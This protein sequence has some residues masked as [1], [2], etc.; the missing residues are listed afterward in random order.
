MDMESRELLQE[1]IGWTAFGYS[2]YFYINPFLT[3]H[4]LIKGKIS[5]EETPIGLVTLSYISCFCWYIYSNLL[6]CNPIKIS[7]LVGTI[8][9]GLLIIIYLYYEIKDYL[10]DTILNALI[11]ITGSYL[12]YLVLDTII[13]NDETVG[14]ICIAVVCILCIFQI[15][16][17]FKALAEKNLN[18]ININQSWMTL[19][20]VTLWGIY[21]YMAS[22]LYVVFPQ[23]LFGLLSIGEITIYAHYKNNKYYT[24]PKKENMPNPSSDHKNDDK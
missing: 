10:K 14:K 13:E 6:S 20:T 4:K 18:Y 3:F 7:N 5:L 22:E 8:I 12:I 15:R 9:N 11:I 16:T 21:G 23:V 19:T 2:L 1:L 24:S 17:I